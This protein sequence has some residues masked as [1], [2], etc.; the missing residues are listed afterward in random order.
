MV[1]TSEHFWCH[2]EREWQCG[3]TNMQCLSGQCP[4]KNAM[5][6]VPF[7][8]SAVPLGFAK[9]RGRGRLA[10]GLACFVAQ[11][12]AIFRSCVSSF[13]SQ[14]YATP[15]L[16]QVDLARPVKRYLAKSATVRKYAF[17]VSERASPLAQNVE[18]L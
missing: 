10:E 4:I 1:E 3:E 17:P 2:Y 13:V 12:A 14:Q 8:S 5:F 18:N 7:H 11:A 9:E 15:C 16:S 6:G